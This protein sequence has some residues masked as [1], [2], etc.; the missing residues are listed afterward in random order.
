MRIRGSELW[1]GGQ[2]ASVVVLSMLLM[3]A[4]VACTTS[5]VLVVTDAAPSE[6]RPGQT[7][8]L[9]LKDGAATEVDIKALGSTGLTT[10]DG[11]RIA[12]AQ[13]ERIEQRQFSAA[14]TAGVVT[15]AVV[16][17]LAVLAAA[18]AN[19]LDDAFDNHK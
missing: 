8:T 10:A 4:Q 2:R 18:F 14:R 17:T 3:L 7:V 19:A 1:R 15:I 12:W 6:V 11:R 13:I 5:R 16:A 9:Y